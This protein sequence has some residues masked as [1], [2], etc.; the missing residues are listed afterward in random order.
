MKR[1][2]VI[3]LF[4]MFAA[5]SVF[6]IVMAFL[7]KSPKKSIAAPTATNQVV[8]LPTPVA[9]DE[10]EATEAPTGE[11]VVTPT[12]APTEEPTP[13]VV[14]RPV[15]N[16]SDFSDL[17][18]KSVSW[19]ITGNWSDDKDRE[20]VKYDID[21]A[22]QKAAEG[23]DYIYRAVDG[24]EK[25][26]Y[27]TFNL[28]YEDTAGS[29]AKILDILKSNN[30]KATFFVSKNYIEENESIV[31]RI[32]EEGHT[33]GSRGD[34]NAKSG[35]NRGMV[36]LGTKEFADTM[37]S[38]EELYQAIAG[39]NT[40]TCFYRPESYSARDMALAEAMGYTVVFRTFD[41]RDWD[42]YYSTSKALQKLKDNTASGAI[43]QLSSSKY[44]VA[45]LENYILWAKDQGYGFAA[46]DAAVKQ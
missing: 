24:P 3:S 45:V 18:T 11:P 23:T 9:T 41:Y 43:Y 16:A 46:I 33:V 35:S 25:T 19:G 27:L 4:I 20:S 30:V 26:I 7:G 32:I 13:D 14:V 22:A 38:V 17:S 34:I 12:A 31:R 8:V 42:D 40:R 15:I 37:W 10:P 39:D 5:V 36:Y 1:S 29:T 28:G 2:N 6:I 44:N 21:S